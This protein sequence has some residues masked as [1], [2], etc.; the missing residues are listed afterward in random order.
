MLLNP[1]FMRICMMRVFIKIV[2]YIKV[3]LR[4]TNYSNNSKVLFL[5]HFV[6][7]IQFGRCRSIG[8]SKSGIC[9]KIGPQKL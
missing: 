4:I 6:V 3:E 2:E 5:N 1:N 8:L 9:S 7:L